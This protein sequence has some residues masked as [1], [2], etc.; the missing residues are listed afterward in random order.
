MEFPRHEIIVR[1][2]KGGKDRVTML[3]AS[4]VAP[5]QPMER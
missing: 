3:P 1:E 2:G 5:L 4:L